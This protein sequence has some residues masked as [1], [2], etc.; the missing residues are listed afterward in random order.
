[1]QKQQAASISVT[2]SSL[3]VQ[4]S[5][6]HRPL[7]SSS[8]IL[9]L[10]LQLYLKLTIHFF[11]QIPHLASLPSTLLPT[12]AFLNYNSTKIR[13]QIPSPPQPYEKIP[14]IYFLCSVSLSNCISIRPSIFLFRLVFFSVPFDRIYLFFTAWSITVYDMCMSWR[15]VVSVPR[16]PGFGLPFER[17]SLQ[18]LP[19]TYGF[20]CSLT[21]VQFTLQLKLFVHYCA[22]FIIRI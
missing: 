21:I 13:K 8:S 3:P 1:M 15:G 19:V 12:T 2:I 4:H 17:D 16:S 7:V 9:C 11:L 22:P 18:A 10:H 5:I 6:G 14:D 20:C